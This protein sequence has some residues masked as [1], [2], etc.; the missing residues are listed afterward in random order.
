MLS[1]FD[2]LRRSRTG[3]ELLA[4]L[5][6]LEEDPGFPAGGD[7]IGP[8]H[9]A[10]DGP[11][12]RCW[13]YARQSG[14]QHCGRCASILARSRALSPAS[15]HALVIWGFVNRL[16]A[17]LREGESARMEHALGAYAPDGNRFLVVT[18]QREIKPWIQGLIFRHGPDLKGNLQIFP[19]LESFRTPGMGDLLCY[20]VHHEAHLPMDQMRVR[21][22]SAPLQVLTPHE[23]DRRKLLTFE[24]SEFLG[25]LDAAEVF[26][27]VLRPEEQ[28]E[29]FELLTLDNAR[30]APFYWGRFVGRLERR[31]KDMLTG[32]NIRAWPRNRVQ[33]LYKLVYYVD[34]PQL[35]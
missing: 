9:S 7:E 10:L 19:T 11:C 30:E 8:P 17:P 28:K 29:L 3:S 14:G 21:F 23:R 35:H 25:L 1:A 26:R 33:L 13:I 20:A 5:M 6:C 24:V 18:P 16:P 22:Y 12:K 15:R 31:A 32:W 2:W 34:L 27:T 4:T